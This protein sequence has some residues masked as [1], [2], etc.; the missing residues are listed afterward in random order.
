MSLQQLASR[1]GLMKNKAA[2][3]V[4]PGT[5]ISNITLPASSR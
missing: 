4:N 3:H 2:I 1:C 5:T